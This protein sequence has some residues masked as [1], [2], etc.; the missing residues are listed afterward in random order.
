MINCTNSASDRRGDHEEETRRSLGTY[1][2]LPIVAV[3]GE[4][5]M[6]YDA[7]GTRLLR[8][9]LRPRG[10]ADRATATRAWWRPSRSRPR[11]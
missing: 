11:G 6:L 9:L 8:F 7:D 5:I 1:A 4:G 10:H 2:K 3:R